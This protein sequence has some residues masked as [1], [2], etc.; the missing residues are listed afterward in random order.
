[1]IVICMAFSADA[2]IQ[3]GKLNILCEE[4]ANENVRIRAIVES[5]NLPNSI[6]VFI[7]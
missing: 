4:M 7:Q 6:A 1:V 3:W 2:K 5:R